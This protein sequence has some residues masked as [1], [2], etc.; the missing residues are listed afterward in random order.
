MLIDNIELQDLTLRDQAG[1]GAG[2]G[3]ES[4]GTPLR[5]F[6]KENKLVL[7]KDQIRE[8]LK[9]YNGLAGLETGQYAT[10][11]ASRDATITSG[12]MEVSGGSRLNYRLQPD[13]VIKTKSADNQYTS[14]RFDN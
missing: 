8:V 13:W 7:S 4:S 5:R 14:L 1:I 11:L 10:N 12:I 9:F 3:I 6:V 2:H